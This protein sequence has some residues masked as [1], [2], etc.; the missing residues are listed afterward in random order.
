MHRVDF[1]NPPTLAVNTFLPQET[2]KTP[3]N[4]LYDILYWLLSLSIFQ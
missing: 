3:L 2:C 1:V 4:Y